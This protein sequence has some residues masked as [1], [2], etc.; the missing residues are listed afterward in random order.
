M[1]TKA[2]AILSKGEDLRRIDIEQIPEEL[3]PFIG[4]YESIRQRV[5]QTGMPAVRPE[6]MGKLSDEE[7]AL[8][9]PAAARTH[10][11]RPC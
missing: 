3:R 11:G 9:Q 7:R 10:G 4:R 5:L 2:A 1:M 6:V 8:A